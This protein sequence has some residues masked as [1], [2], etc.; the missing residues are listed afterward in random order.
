MYILTTDKSLSVGD[1]DGV[2]NFHMVIFTP[3]VKLTRRCD[4]QDALIFEQIVAT[5]KKLLA[6]ASRQKPNFLLIHICYY[7]AKNED[8]D[9][10]I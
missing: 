4:G 2:N 3:T 9:Y 8:G 5:A 10:L 7:Y 6:E 1:S